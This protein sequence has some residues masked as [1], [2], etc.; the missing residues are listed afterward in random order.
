MVARSVTHHPRPLLNRGGESFSWQRRISPG[1]APSSPECSERDLNTAF[2][3]FR[4]AL[5]A[6]VNFQ[7]D[8]PARLAFSG[9]RGRVITASGPW[10]SSGEWWKEDGWESEEWDLE[11]QYSNAE[12]KAR[13]GVYRVVYDLNRKKWFVEGAYD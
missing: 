6:T 11:V 3:V 12:A 9:C 4:P 10:R 2:R 13:T 8:R 7:R 5:P 1:D